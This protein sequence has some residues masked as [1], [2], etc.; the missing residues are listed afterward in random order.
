MNVM[1]K[2]IIAGGRDFTDY[3][4][5]ESTLLH[6]FSK[7]SDVEIVSGVAP[8]A[9]TLAIQFAA[10]HNIMGRNFLQIGISLANQ[11]VIK[12]IYRW[13]DMPMLVSA[14]GTESLKVLQT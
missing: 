3:A 8:G 12:E 4:L 10:Q 5:L 2:V 9:D 14:S 1:F 7:K 6:L 13:P 11:P